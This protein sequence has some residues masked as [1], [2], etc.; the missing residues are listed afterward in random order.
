MRITFSVLVA[1]ATA[2]GN[3]HYG[4]DTMDLDGVELLDVEAWAL[5]ADELLIR[6][7]SGVPEGAHR[8]VT[9]GRG[10]MLEEFLRQGFAKV[11]AEPHPP[12]RCTDRLTEEDRVTRLA[13]QFYNTFG[14][15]P[16]H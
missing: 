15:P 5:E 1:A 2:T 9:S 3:S 13:Q 8:L 11:C 16:P 6:A 10:G 12:A 14:Q 7:P 4:D